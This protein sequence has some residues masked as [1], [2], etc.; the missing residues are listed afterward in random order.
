MRVRRSLGPDWKRI[1]NR[2][3]QN[4]KVLHPEDVM[5]RQRQRY[6][7]R[8]ASF[9]ELSKK[10]GGEPRHRRR[11]MAMRSARRT[12]RIAAETLRQKRKAA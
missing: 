11:L 1:Q 12:Y 7:I 8:T 5:T 10:Y 9:D 4:G 3:T 2:Q 6:L